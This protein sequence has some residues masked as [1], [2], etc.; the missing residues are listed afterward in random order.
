MKENIRNKRI[1]EDLFLEM[2]KGVLEQWPTGRDVRLEEAIDYQTSLPEAKSFL[3]VT[4]DLHREGKTVVFPR[5]GTPLVEDEISLCRSLEEIGIPLIP[6]TTD[7]YTRAL[8]LRKVEEALA[9]SARVGKPMLNGYPLIN[10]GVKATRKIVESVHGGAFNPRL[11]RI[12]Y[13]LGAEI[14][15]AAGMTGIALSAF[16]SFGAYEKTC[17][18]QDSIAACQYVARLMGYYAG[19]GV[20]MTADHHGWIPTSVFPLSVNIA[21]MIADAVISAEQGV[22]SVIPL[23]HSM[24]N[25]AQDLAWTRVT[26]R[27]MR[28]YLDRL[29]YGKVI[30]AGAFLAQTPLYPMPQGVGAAFAS[31]N[32][33]ATLAALA[34]VE[35]VFLR[36][37]DE[38]A[39]IPT[40]EAHAVTYASANWLFNVIRGQK[41][42]VEIEGVREE[43]RITELEVRAILDRLLEIGEGDVIVGAVKAV[44]T[45]MLD[46]SFSPN[47]NVKDHVLGVK[48]SR[49]AIRYAEFGDLPIPEEAK[50]FHREKVAQRAR[51]EGRKMDYTVM[52]EDLWAFSKGQLVGKG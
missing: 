33:V 9:E 15:F 25:L 18:L 3:R 44:E 40:E 47:R 39:G 17:T 42:D 28:E 24:G 20:V 8:Q 45:G 6:V 22:M 31:L 30:M 5:A 49:G 1:D 34:K 12:S 36:T 43:E 11:S 48:D 19:R 41:I 27:L 2:R 14:A 10:H 51:S 38:G 4:Q 37:I 16:V 23:V 50:E 26:P 52:V 35:S 13:P 29:G 7:S 46:S 21:T 32:Y